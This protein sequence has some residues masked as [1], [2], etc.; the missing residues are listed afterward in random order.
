MFIL[1]LLSAAPFSRG[2]RRLCLLLKL[3]QCTVNFVNRQTHHIEIGALNL[4]HRHI[5]YPLLHTIGAGLVQRVIAG[6]IIVDLFFTQ[7][8][9]G[10]IRNV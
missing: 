6:E 3:F 8:A 1:S 2:T 5:A 7:R 10:D 9:E 4:F